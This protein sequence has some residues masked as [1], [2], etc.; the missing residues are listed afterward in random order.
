MTR[1][2]WN[3]ALILGLL[4]AVATVG[5]GVWGWTGP[6]GDDPLD[7]LYKALQAFVLSENYSDLEQA[8]DARLPLEA[9]RWLGALFA[10]YAI[11]VLVWSSLGLWRLGLVARGRRGHLVVAGATVFADRLS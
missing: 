3:G 5:L 9:A 1:V 11:L 10:F 7:A 4:A 6:G 8:A 2:R